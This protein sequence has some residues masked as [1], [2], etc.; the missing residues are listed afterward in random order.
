MP[1]VSW[2]VALPGDKEYEVDVP[3]PVGDY[4]SDK[5]APIRGTEA[6]DRVMSEERYCCQKGCLSK[7]KAYFKGPMARRIITTERTLTAGLDPVQ[8]L[9]FH[10]D[11]L[12]VIAKAVLKEAVAGDYK[13]L[14]GKWGG[15]LRFLVV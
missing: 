7:W 11:R 15:L 2:P 10:E 12:K 14:V 3:G 13:D 9:I 8:C 5:T 6:I 4:T 1:D